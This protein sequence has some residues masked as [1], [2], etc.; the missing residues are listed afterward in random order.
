M[1][2]RGIGTGLAKA[3]SLQEQG[4]EQIKCKRGLRHGY[5]CR[6]CGGAVFN[7]RYWRGARVVD[8]VCLENRSARKGT[9]GSNPSLSANAARAA[10]DRGTKKEAELA[11]SL[12]FCSTISG[13]KAAAALKPPL[14]G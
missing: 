6:P 10:G 5:I 13:R 12:L 1:V 2:C 14:K 7:A 9:G 3:F 11:Q 4:Q 8:R